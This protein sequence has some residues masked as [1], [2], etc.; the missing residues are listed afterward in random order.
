VLPRGAEAS[1]PKRR[2]AG[3]LASFV[4]IAGRK[5]IES[6]ASVKVRDLVGFP[7]VRAE[8]RG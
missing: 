1:S 3:V 5:S 6:G 7:P 4:G 8:H 2:L